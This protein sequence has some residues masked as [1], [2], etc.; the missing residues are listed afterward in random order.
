MAAAKEQVSVDAAMY[1]DFHRKRNLSMASF[2]RWVP[3]MNPKDLENIPS[4]MQR[5]RT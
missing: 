5:K 2:I 3:E 4:S 1:L